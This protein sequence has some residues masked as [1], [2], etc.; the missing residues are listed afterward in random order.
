MIK[1]NQQHFNRLHV[2]IDAF[3]IVVSYIIAWWLKFSSGILDSPGGALSFGF[4]M[5][6]LVVIV[7]LYL[8]LYY[9]FNLYTPK[10]VQGRRL[11]FSNVVMANIVGFLLIFTVLYNLQSYVDQ[12]RNFSR[13]MF[14]YFFAINTVLEESFR[15]LIRQFLRTIRKNGY[16]LKH[17]LLVGYS[18][19]AEQY[20]DRIQQNPQWGYNVRGILDDNIA[21][22][23]TYKGIK[24]IGSIGNLLYILPENKLDEIAITLGLEE[25]YKLEKIVAEC[26]KSGV[27]TKFIPD[28][29]NIIPTKPYTEDLLGLPVINIRYVPLNNTFNALVKRA[30]DIAGSIVGIIVTSPLM[31]LMCA[32]IKLTSPGPLIYKQERVGLH[33]QTFRMY[34]FRSMEVQPESEE[35]KA[36]TVKNDPRVTPIGKFMRHTSIDELPQLF[37]ILKGNMSLVGPRPERPFFVEKFREEIPRYMVKHQVR[38]GLTG[39]AQVNGYRGDTSIRKRIEYD[40]YY[41]ENWSIGLD[42]KI[43]FLTF[44]KGF[45]NKN[46]Y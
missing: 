28:Y 45:I 42:I 30:M 22:G 37:N 14:F 3:V 12:F 10:R 5:K 39:W 1:D 11:E 41:I 32:I 21:R 17:V 27:H 9:A 8:I 31:L 38:P 34:K 16:N 6:A 36:W 7:P 43:I 29:G 35:K 40:L 2:I 25:Y 13:E 15:L 20:I 23:T 26:E 46:A 4:Y 33:N 24:V 44:F 18:R 19:A